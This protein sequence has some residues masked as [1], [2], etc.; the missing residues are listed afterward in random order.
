MRGAAEYFIAEWL[1]RT[2]FRCQLPLRPPQCAMRPNGRVPG[3]V[4]GEL[5][6]GNGGRLNAGPE[7][8][9]SMC[10]VDGIPAEFTRDVADA[11]LRL[12]D[13]DIAPPA[14]I[15]VEQLILRV[16]GPVPRI[17]PEPAMPMI[18]RGIEKAAAVMYD[19]DRDSV[20]PA[21]I[22]AVFKGEGQRVALTV[23]EQIL[24]RAVLHIE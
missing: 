15:G 11:G 21:L 3:A 12:G 22:Q 2:E 19:G 9:G 20:A 24:V 6:H 1:C 10:I 13:I 14:G 4:A 5:R 8:K 18:D 7:G 23:H 16:E 17:E